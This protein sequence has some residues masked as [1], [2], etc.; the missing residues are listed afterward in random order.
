M[1]HNHPRERQVVEE[2]S[3]YTVQISRWFAVCCFLLLTLALLFASVGCGGGSIASLQSTSRTLVVEPQ[4]VDFGTVDAL[5]NMVAIANVRNIGVT[6]VTL[7]SATTTP[8]FSLANWPGPVTLRPQ[9]SIQ[10]D[11]RFEPFTAGAYQGFVQITSRTNDGFFSVTDSQSRSTPV[12]RRMFLRLSGVSPDHATGHGKGNGGNNSGGGPVAGQL[13]VSP[14]TLDFGNVVVSQSKGLTTTLTATGSA[15]T[16]FSATP[17]TSEFTVSGPPLPV[18][19]AAGQTAVFDVIF[20]PKASGTTNATA[21]F[22]SNASDSI[23]LDSLTGTGTPAPQHSVD[24]SW[25][26][27][28]SSV[29]GYNVYRGTISGGPF[30]K[31]NTVLEASTTYTDVTVRSGTKYY[32]VTT[33]VDGNGLESAYSNQ[34]SAVIPTP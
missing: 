12:L 5:A 23:V 6:D 1:C 13:A 19:I 21:S 29:V 30:T 8:G 31:I 16:V 24:L 17:S 33:A 28:T 14:S 32:Y 4:V 25:N 10:L 3:P 20:N 18:T 27:S 15:I 34:A 7:L 22:A 26:P 9:E 11:L 2:K